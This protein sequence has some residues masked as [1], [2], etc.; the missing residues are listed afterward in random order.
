[1]LLKEKDSGLLIEVLDLE[2]LFLP[3]HDDV[4]GQKQAGEEEQDPELYL[5][6]KLMFPS[7]ENLPKCWLNPNYQSAE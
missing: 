4:L 3:T 1:M 5:K 6:S 7:D 2:A